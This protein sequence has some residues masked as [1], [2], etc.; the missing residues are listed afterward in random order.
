MLAYFLLKVSLNLTVP[1]LS[2]VWILSELIHII[3]VRVKGSIVTFKSTLWPRKRLDRVFRKPLTASY[4]IELTFY[5][6]ETYAPWID[7]VCGRRGCR[8]RHDN[9]C[10]GGSANLG[11]RRGGAA[12]PDRAPGPGPA[13][14]RRAPRRPLVCRAALPPRS[15]APP[16]CHALAARAARAASA[17][18]SR[19]RTRPYARLARRSLNM[20]PVL[21]YRSQVSIFQVKLS[22]FDVKSIELYFDEIDIC[23]W[24]VFLIYYL[25]YQF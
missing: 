2:L 18:P 8:Q 9:Y 10:A 15:A 25:L 22:S 12:R 23:W 11:H 6:H 16:L 14:P 20:L 13:S 4:S 3:D 5:F 7:R 17:A 24:V 1:I 19:R 21:W